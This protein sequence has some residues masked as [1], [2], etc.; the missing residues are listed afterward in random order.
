VLARVPAAARADRQDGKPARPVAAAFRKLANADVD[1]SLLLPVRISDGE[2]FAV[3][4]GHDAAA[5]ALGGQ[6]MSE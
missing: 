5:G 2:S 6:V 3:V 1:V 4:C